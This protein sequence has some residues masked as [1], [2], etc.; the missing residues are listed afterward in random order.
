MVVELELVPVVEP[1]VAVPLVVEDVVLT[2]VLDT[3]VPVVPVDVPVDVAVVVLLPVVPM[4]APV[5]VAVVALLPVDV[6][7]VPLEGLIGEA[8]GEAVV[9]VW[10]AVI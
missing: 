4:D 8:V 6:P 9:G 10:V 5:D 2:P 7:V 3:L 1:V